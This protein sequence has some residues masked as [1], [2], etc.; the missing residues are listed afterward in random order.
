MNWR[1]AAIVC[2]LLAPV[3]L[4]AGTGLVGSGVFRA[5]ERS[6]LDPR[7]L[8]FRAGRSRDVVTGEAL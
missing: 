6:I 3:V 5:N 7:S 8:H 1:A 2:G 4:L